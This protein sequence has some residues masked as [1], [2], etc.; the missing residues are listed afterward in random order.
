MLLMAIRIVCNSS[1]SKHMQTLAMLLNAPIDF[2]LKAKN[3]FLK[4][5]NPF[6]KIL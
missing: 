4:N 5:G 1:T 6:I 2:S 3:E